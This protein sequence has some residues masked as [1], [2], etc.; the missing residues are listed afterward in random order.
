MKVSAITLEKENALNNL[1][2]LRTLKAFI[3]LLSIFMKLA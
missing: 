3:N 1:I 2:I